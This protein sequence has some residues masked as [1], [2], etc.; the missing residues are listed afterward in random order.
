[1]ITGVPELQEKSVMDKRKTGCSLE[2]AS[3]S[4]HVLASN[5]NG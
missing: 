5:A 3:K 2:I 1:M 4:S